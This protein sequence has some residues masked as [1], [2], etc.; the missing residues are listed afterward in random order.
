MDITEKLKE[1]ILSETKIDINQRTRK[2]E[3]VEARALYCILLKEI[4]PYR[5]LQYIANTLEL[6]HATVIHALKGY[7]YYEKFNP[8][9]NK[10]KNNILRYFNIE[11]TLVSNTQEDLDIKIIKYEL[12][13][14]KKDYELLKNDTRIEFR[15][16]KELNN[17]LE[18]TKGTEQHELITLRLEAFYSMNKNIR[19]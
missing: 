15:I 18:A 5:T 19:L 3:I 14:L 17:L 16:I 7:E 6:N 1:L 13:S 11:H 8:I 12:E 9:L 4:Q 10:Y 2:R